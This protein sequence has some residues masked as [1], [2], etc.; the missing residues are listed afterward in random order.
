MLLGCVIFRRRHL[1]TDRNDKG[2]RHTT[3]NKTIYNDNSI[4]QS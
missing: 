3:Q 1:K 2:L 4:D